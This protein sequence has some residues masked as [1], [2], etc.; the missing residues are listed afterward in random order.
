MIFPGIR[1]FFQEAD[2][3]KVRKK[4]GSKKVQFKDEPDK[5]EVDDKNDDGNVSQVLHLLTSI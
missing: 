3:Q 4:G 1:I 2:D 5:P